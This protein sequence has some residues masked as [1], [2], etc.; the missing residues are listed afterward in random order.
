MTELDNLCLTLEGELPTSNLQ[1]T[2]PMEAPT[3]MV[4]CVFLALRFFVHLSFQNFLEEKVLSSQ[5]EFRNREPQVITFEA[6]KGIHLRLLCILAKALW[7]ICL[8]PFVHFSS[9]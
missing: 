3:G 4:R 2:R 8:C 5:T 1:S 7:Y 9:L 6:Q